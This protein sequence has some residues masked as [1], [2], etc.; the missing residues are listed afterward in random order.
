MSSYDDALTYMQDTLF[1]GFA[2]P[3]ADEPDFRGVSFSLTAEQHERLETAC[4]AALAAHPAPTGA[5]RN[6]HALDVIVSVY[7][8]RHG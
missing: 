2:L 5:N 4:R 7:L 1:G 6:A 3:N 8:A